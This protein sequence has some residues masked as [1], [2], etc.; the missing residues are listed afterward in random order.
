M[1]KK[2]ALILTV[3]LS[4][5]CLFGCSAGVDTKKV[6]PQADSNDTIITVWS[7]SGGGQAVW[8]ELVDQWNANEGDEKN[9]FINWKTV[10][11][12][13]QH[14]VAQQSGQLP[15][16]VSLNLSRINKFRTS[17]DI[18]AI[19]DLPGGEE[20]VKEYNFPALDGV[21]AFD[22][23]TYRLDREATIAGLAYNKDLFK[24]AGIVDENGEAKAPKTIS[25]LREAA[26]KITELGGGVYGFAF[27]LKFGTY[28]TIDMPTANSFSITNPAV[29]IDLDNL[30]VSY[31]GYKDKF[32]WILDMKEDGSIFPGAVTLDN[33]TARAY[34]SAGTIGMIPAISW[35]VGVYTTQFP[36]ECDWDVCQFPLIDGKGLYQNGHSISGGLAVS[37]NAVKDEKTAAATMEVYKFIYSL[38]TRTTLFEQGI[39]MSCK[40]DV[41]ETADT[42]KTDPRHLKFAS[43]LPE[44]IK[45]YP[46][47]SYVLEGENWDVL[48]Q[49]VWMGDITLDEAI[50]DIETRATAGLR[51]SVSKGIYDVQKQ[52][53]IEAQ[54]L[55]D[56]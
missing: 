8:E 49:K 44:E 13:Q 36:A 6:K 5:V 28:Y 18:V 26:K 45:R 16:I 35:D 54:K 30:T 41:L 53:Q 56:N 2:M 17:G 22:G 32:Q 11:D 37:K 47:Q 15:E 14:D 19:E 21:N 10:M 27:P 20:F 31:S 29:K 39:E 34:F 38:D 4:V 55:A 9:I 46:S 51:D 50:K 23:K 7:G 40:S 1:K 24:K 25:E 43:F 42:S 48:F 33:D 52:K 12:S 3:V